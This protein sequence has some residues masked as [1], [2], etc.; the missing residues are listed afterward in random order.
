MLEGLSGDSLEADLDMLAGRPSLLAKLPPAESAAIKEAQSYSPLPTELSSTELSGTELTANLV[1]TSFIAAAT[2]FFNRETRTSSTRWPP[3]TEDTYNPGPESR[4][5]LGH[6]AHSVNDLDLSTAV[7]RTRAR[8]TT[9]HSDPSWSSASAPGGSFHFPRH[10]PAMSGM[11]STPGFDWRDRAEEGSICCSSDCDHSVC[12]P[13]R[14]VYSPAS[15]TSIALDTQPPTTPLTPGT[16]AT[17]D[18]TFLSPTGHHLFDEKPLPCIPATTHKLATTIAERRGAKALALQANTAPSPAASPKPRLLSPRTPDSASSFAQRL[19]GFIRPSTPDPA[20]PTTLSCREYVEDPFGDASPSFFDDPYLFD[21]APTRPHPDLYDLS[22]Y[23]SDL[24]TARAAWPAKKWGKHAR[25][26]LYVGVSDLQPDSDSPV[27]HPSSQAHPAPSPDRP[28]H[29]PLPAPAPAPAPASA[30]TPTP[31]PP[32]SSS[33]PP[34]SPSTSS[35]SSSPP[36]ARLLTRSA[37][38]PSSV[39][40]HLRPL[41]LPQKL[42]RR[43]IADAQSSSILRHTSVRL[44][45]LILPQELARRASYPPRRVHARPHHKHITSYPSALR[46]SHNW[47][48]SAGVVFGAMSMA[49]ATNDAPNI[50]ETKASKQEQRRSQQL[51]DLICLLDQSGILEDVHEEHEAGDVASSDSEDSAGLA[52]PPTLVSRPESSSPFS[53]ISQ[54]QADCADDASA[55]QYRESR[56]LEDILELLEKQQEGAPVEDRVAEEPLAQ[57]GENEGSIC[58]YAM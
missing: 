34:L 3:G 1:M 38:L 55:R 12:S 22:M 41:L 51:D 49:E 37:P 25:T 29:I 40:P 21:A 26:R 57:E 20:S 11:L 53:L 30:R 45:P 47:T 32:P 43:E 5:F 13:P 46:H 24:Q 10:A 4:K 6:K 15:S 17:T 52:T 50:A 36:T 16:P 23:A 7:S 42:A 48:L 18:S 8:G 39:L 2:Q 31:I 33:A 54:S 9:A 27:S 28:A 44:R 56:N 58:A 19:V 14:L 35:S